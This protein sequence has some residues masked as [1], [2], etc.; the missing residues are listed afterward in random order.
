MSKL[1]AVCGAVVTLPFVVAACGDDGAVDTTTGAS[2]TGVGGAGVGGGP[3]SSGP[4]STG[5][6]GMGGA[7]T[8]GDSG[9]SGWVGEVPILNNDAACVQWGKVAPGVT[10]AGHLYGVRL[11]PPSYPFDVNE[12]VYELVDDG[13]TCDATPAHRVEVYVDT[14][15]APP[16]MPNAPTVLNVPASSGHSGVRVVKVSLPTTMT[17]T[18]GQ[19][20]F[21]AVALPTAGT[22]CIAACDGAT[23]TDR[24]F[25]S[26]AA[27]VPYNWSTLAS[28]GFLIHARIGANGVT[29]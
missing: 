15:V 5:A 20:L 25:W 4:A 14:A 16:N 27:M 18:A 28:D 9:P 22:S 6:G 2:T 29:N 19:Y 24:D 21:V 11:V 3:A 23:I 12:V 13:D 7:G 26:N 8:G 17:L 1:I 10:E